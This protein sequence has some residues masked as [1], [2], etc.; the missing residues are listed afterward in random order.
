MPVIVHFQLHTRMIARAREIKCLE[1]RIQIR[2]PLNRLCH[3]RLLH[4]ASE[5]WNLAAAANHHVST[6]SIKVEI[7]LLTV[8]ADLDLFEGLVHHHRGLLHHRH[9]HSCDDAHPD[10]TARLGGLQITRRHLLLPIH[11]PRV[12]TWFFGL[13]GQTIL[14]WSHICIGHLPNR[15]HFVVSICQYQIFARNH[16]TPRVVRK[17]FPM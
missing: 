10:P 8:S 16:P 9:R 1:P 15:C 7:L 6:V 12:T 5:N 17:D 3:L 11:I 2:V 14:S 13:V 4:L